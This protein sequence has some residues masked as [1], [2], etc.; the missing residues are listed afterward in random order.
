MIQPSDGSERAP[1]ASMTLART[2]S[3]RPLL[4]PASIVVVGGSSD[5][6]KA[7]GRPLDYL[8]RSGFRG[9]VTAVNPAYDE[10]AGVPCY[11]DLDTVPTPTDLCIIAVPSESIE[12]VLER[13]AALGIPAAIVF[14]S[15]FGEL[16][17]EGRDRQQRLVRIAE[18]GGIALLGPN[19][20]GLANFRSGALATFTTALEV[21]IEVPQGRIAFVSQSGAIG[22]FVLQ[23]A[24]Q[25][26][27]G[28]SHFVTTG[29]EAVIGFTDV[30]RYFL[31]DPAT[32]VIAGYLEGVDGQELV[33]LATAALE[34][35]K[36]L[37][38]MKVGSSAAGARASVSHTGKMVGRDE[39][40][41]A[42]FRRHGIVRADSI[43]ALLDISR[44]LAIA[45]RPQ[46]SRAGI[47]SISG[48]AAILMADA[49]AAAGLA[50]HSLSRDTRSALEELLPEF[51]TPGNPLDVTGR[52]LWEEG[53]LHGALT[54][55]GRDPGVDVLLIHVGLA[56]G[57]EDRIADEIATA[58]GKT[59]KPALVC[60]VPDRGADW[61]RRLRDA[62]IPVFDD[63]VKLVSAASAIVQFADA[64]RRHDAADSERS[65]ITFPHPN[66][67][68]GPVMAEASAKSLLQQWGLRVPRAQ[69]V[70]TAEDAAR[71]AEQLGYP[72]VVK[73]V[74]PRLTHRAR[75]GAVRTYLHDAPHVRAAFDDVVAAARA[76]MPGLPI[77]GVLVEAMVAGGYELYVAATRDPSFGAAIACG[78]GGVNVEMLGHTSTELAPIAREDA[79]RMLASAGLTPE[80]ADRFD[81]AA[82][83]DVLI[84]LSDVIGSL[85]DVQTIEV[86]P[87]AVLP[88]GLGAVAL[89]ALIVRDCSDADS[90]EAPRCR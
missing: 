31:D 78:P 59:T 49:S 67:E 15:G 16:G 53:M 40:Y 84:S 27:V 75:I 24:Q 46:G 50:V 89:D 38:V 56:P 68:S 51:A 32:S 61:Y 29:N 17:S 57:V 43:E 20:L 81:V 83:A 55:L 39:L 90:K 2:A 74:S 41:D 71:A 19:C 45:S 10:I 34:A 47:V 66:W 62:G 11:P 33:A 64:V 79:T 1:T 87:L 82:A 13:C 37:V 25:R 14:A 18:E 30:A 77:E 65:E 9:Q 26:Q 22:A 23:L 85:S 70:K 44:A 52:P 48:G 76:H 21:E 36:P 58:V 35:R 8:S 42:A 3:L 12:G 28:L 7:G 88:P 63:P 69:L 60:W 5:P 6:R 54:A 86:N 4:D 73:L 80:V 72:V